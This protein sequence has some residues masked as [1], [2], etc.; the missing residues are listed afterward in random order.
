MDEQQPSFVDH[1]Q[2]VL[3]GAPDIDDEKRADLYDLFH[4]SKNADELARHL[5]AIPVPDALK[6]QLY[7]AKKKQSPA[8]EP[9]DKA[10]DAISRIGKLDPKVLQLAEQ[11]PTVTKALIT[12]ATAKAAG[13]GAAAPKEKTSDKEKKA[14]LVGPDIKATPSGHALVRTHDGG[15]HHIPA[16]NIEKAKSIDPEL[17]VLHVEP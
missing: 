16:E 6:T 1:A 17:T 12:A 7:D 3:A 9:I 11:F 4:N 15:L 8:A 10:T 13:E 2:P 5:S 14:P